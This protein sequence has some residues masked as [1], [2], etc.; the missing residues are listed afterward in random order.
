MSQKPV[1]LP[2]A[3]WN[4]PIIRAHRAP[5]TQPAAGLQ[6]RPFSRPN[7]ATQ[8]RVSSALPSAEIFLFTGS[9]TPYESHE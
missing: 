8:Q 3:W 9:N 5:V 6:R 1:Q 4:T 2:F 7:V